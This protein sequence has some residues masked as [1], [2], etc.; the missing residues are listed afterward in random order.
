M[1]AYLYVLTPKQQ[2]VYYHFFYINSEVVARE[3][4]TLSLNQVARTFIQL[5]ST[6]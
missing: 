6:N 3:Y 1:D 2:V 4:K 5:L